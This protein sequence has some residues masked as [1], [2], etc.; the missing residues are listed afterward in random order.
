MFIYLLM[1]FQIKYIFA[2]K[3]GSLNNVVHNPLNDTV[4]SPYR[5]GNERQ[6]LHSTYGG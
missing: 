6:F 2:I 5:R 1:I 4:H 3:V